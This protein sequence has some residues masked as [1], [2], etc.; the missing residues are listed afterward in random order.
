MVEKLMIADAL[1]I[2]SLETLKVITD[3][4]RMEIIK[5]IGYANK[6][7]ELRTVKQL[8]EELDMKVSKLYYHI[9]MLEDHELIHVG[10]TQV[11]SGIIEKHYQVA[12][13][14]MSID[15]NLMMA[16][17][18]IADENLDGVMQGIES[19]VQS[20]LSDVRKS[21]RVILEKE[22][23]EK[24][25]GVISP[26]QTSLDVKNAEIFLTKEQAIEFQKAGTAL[27]E[28]YEEI[29]NKN[30]ED[31]VEDGLYYSVTTIMTPLFHRD[32]KQSAS[33][34]LEA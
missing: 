23:E 26:E 19:V 7:G 4:T 2:S 30:H 21:L 27:L 29:A 14:S 33:Y 5:R 32:Y 6:A 25:T 13:C 8:S 24:K 10:E 31:Q 34:K 28:K 15:K 18:S 16:G 20:A 3:A 9:K 1:E 11:I 12:A 17:D 22:L